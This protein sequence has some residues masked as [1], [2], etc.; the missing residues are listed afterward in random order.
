MNKEIKIFLFSIH[1]LL[2]RKTSYF[3][4]SILTTL[5]FIVSSASFIVESITKELIL[6]HEEL[7]DVVIQKITGGRQQYIPSEYID[8]ILDIPGISN[9]YP[10]IWGYYYF[11]Y[12]SVNFTLI[13]IDPLEPM[14]KNS[15]EKVFSGFDLQY[16]IKNNDW[17]IMG[18]GIGELFDKIAYSREAYFRMPNGEYLS[19]KPIKILDKDGAIFTN[20]FAIVSKSSARKIL[21]MPEGLYTDIAI[22]VYN[23]NEIDTISSKIRD[24]LKDV[25]TVS[26]KD[27]LNS[28]RNVFS[29]K[30]GFFISLFGILIFTMILI[31]ADKLSGLSQLEKTEIGVMK[32]TGWTTGDV[33]KLKF[34]EAG[35]IS[36]QA[37][38]FATFLALVYVF[39]LKAPLM[40]DIFSGYASL[41]I[42]YSLIFAINFKVLFFTFIS[43]VP[44]Y[45]A[46]TII[47]SYKIAITDTY[48]VFK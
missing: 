38:I 33:L 13:G 47:P 7:P 46:A 2:K 22:T 48:E 35:F 41:R 17:L 42:N 11:D 8:K 6:T 32:A 31:V 15:L 36:F 30:S 5:V 25:R 23:K 12:A 20:D 16:L 14:Y 10:R 37:F 28:Y 1:L 43:V 40:I 27:I 39:I 21:G 4:F 34:Y 24:R 44:F 18:Y 19:L 29:Y 3:I 9:I 45:V 26:K